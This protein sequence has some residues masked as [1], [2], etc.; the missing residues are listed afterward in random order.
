MLQAIIHKININRS[1]QR[2][3]FQIPIADSYESIVGIETNCRLDVYR[4]NFLILEESSATSDIFFAKS[5]QELWDRPFLRTPTIGTLRLS[6]NGSAFIDQD[7]PL[8]THSMNSYEVSS[9][10]KS[11]REIDLNFQSIHQSLLIENSGIIEGYY[12]DEF[13]KGKSILN[14]SYSLTIV[15]WLKKH[16]ISL[17]DEN[18]NST[19]AD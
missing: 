8:L 11:N 17:N 14:P 19:R 13:H 7:L 16:S 3:Y 12:K 15:L 2:I 1:D 6:S 10:G 5:V 4:D 9:T 18:R